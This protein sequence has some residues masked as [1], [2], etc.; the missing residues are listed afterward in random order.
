MADKKRLMLVDGHAL[1]Y[2][3]YHAIP[4]LT[5]PKG[6]PSNAT[7]G[8]ANILLKA[9]AD[10][11]PDYVIATFDLGRTF[12]HEEYSEYKATRAE[13]P[14]DLRVHGELL[15]LDTKDALH[16]RDHPNILGNPTGNCHIL[17]DPHL[18]REINDALCHGFVD[19]CRKCWFL[20]PIAD[21]VF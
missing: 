7:F 16:V 20:H 6:E 9:I 5:T 8:F 14:D 17:R 13:T 12:R 2:R 10:T 4:P 21:S 1:A 3:A 15:E 11:K 19:R 18:L